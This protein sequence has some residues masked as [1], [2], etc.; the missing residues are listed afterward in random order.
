MALCGAALFTFDF[1]HLVQTRIATID[2]YGVFFILV[3]YYFMYRWLTV[4][5]GKK[6]RLLVG[7]AGVVDLVEIGGVHVGVLV[8]PQLVLVK[9]G[10]GTV[11]HM[12]RLGEGL[13]SYNQPVTVDT[14]SLYTSLGTGYYTLEWEEEDGR[15]YSLRP[16][17]YYNST[18]WRKTRTR[19]R[20]PDPR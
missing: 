13:F 17:Q 4:P 5:A 6:L 9:Q 14:V 10:G 3:S 1:M 16:E 15:W 12:I 11:V 18:D 19:L 8:R 20:A 2:T 7:G